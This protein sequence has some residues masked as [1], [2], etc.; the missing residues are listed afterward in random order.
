MRGLVRQSKTALQ[1]RKVALDIVG[2]LNQKDYAGELR[3]LQQF[4]RDQIRY[5]RD[6]RGVETVAAPEY[7]LHS[8]QGDC[9]D[10]SVLLATL[11]ESIGHPTR[12]VAVGYT[13]GEYAHVLVD[14]R[15]G[16]GWIPAETTEPVDVGWY[17]P[18]MASRLVIHN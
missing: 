10:Q 15:L 12:F 6:I 16:A 13:P 18:N 5:V 9:D 4:V 8:R 1:L 2:P 11:L 3:A 17:P 14:S 7:T